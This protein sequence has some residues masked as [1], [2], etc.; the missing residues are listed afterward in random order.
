MFST[1]K[2]VSVSG[3]IRSHRFISTLT[4]P[5]TSFYDFSLH[6]KIRAGL[7]EIANEHV[8]LATGSTSASR[9]I[10]QQQS[11]CR[12]CNENAYLEQHLESCIFCLLCWML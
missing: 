3:Q 8:L 6:H 11:V 9:W 7:C 1:T 4:E 2:K 10:C 5:L 12:Q